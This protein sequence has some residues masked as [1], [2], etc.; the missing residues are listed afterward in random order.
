M[1]N[2][3]VMLAVVLSL[4]VLLGWNFLFPTPKPVP[5]PT[6]A[7]STDAASPGKE[8]PTPGMTAQTPAPPLT[9]FAPAPGRM[10]TVKTPRYTAV[11]NSLG[12]VLDSFALSGFHQTIA[13]DSPLV[14][15]VSD[16]SRQKAPLGLLINGQPTWQAAQWSLEGGDLELTPGQSGAL[17]FVGQLGDLRIERTLT[18]TADAYLFTEKLA[19]TNAAGAPVSLKVAN[20]LSVDKLSEKSESYNVTKVAYYGDSGLHEVTDMK[21]L[22]KGVVADKAI[23]WAGV[24]SN[25]FLMAGVALEPGYLAK[26][27]FEDGVY[28]VAMEKDGVAV[29]A[30][31]R[32]ELPSAYYLGP[33]EMDDLSKAPGNLAASVNYGW[34]DFIAKPLLLML[35]FLHGY[36]GNYGVA[37]ILLTII[38]KIVFWP[39][40][41]KS[42]KSMDQL[43]KLQPLM[44][45]IREKH[46]D[47]R[48][49]MNEE[50][51]RLYK[52]YKVNPA[53]GCLPMV[54][55]IPVFIGL[56]QALLNA[57]ELR[58][59]PFITH[60]PFTDI[61]WLADLSVKDP[62]YVTPIIMGAT[63]FL[64]QKMTPAPGDPTQA[65][66]ML[67]LPVVFTFMFL[68]F[69][70][71]LV[72][73]WL[74]NNVLSIAQQWH[75]INKSKK[76]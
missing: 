48:Q 76:A 60:V 27:K 11:F 75:L 23:T 42:Y 14:N 50:M 33:K 22:E 37:I 7:A 68:N 16:L 31:S 54:V 40:T 28:R 36:V 64:Q 55:Q 66:I 2:K 45:Q 72:V 46:K 18:F 26:A 58:H 32:V 52:T 43:R 25:Y 19:L 35:D 29:T 73:Y 49:Q 51:M 8:A 9:A 3:R 15:L 56:Y 44:A 20:I 47:D 61:I 4:A 34:F 30:G 17:T 39:L 5:Q 13:T 24:E 12:G 1:E 67:A 74:V 10:V 38:I 71:G 70:S 53:G 63:M 21:D 59:A 6:P 65:K 62:F 41:H 57:I 69:P